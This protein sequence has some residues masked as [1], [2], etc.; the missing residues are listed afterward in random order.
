MGNV[1]DNIALYI[2]IIYFIVIYSMIRI[3]FSIIF[4]FLAYYSPVIEI[5]YKDGTYCSYNL[6]GRYHNRYRP[7]VVRPNGEFIWYYNGMI[8]RDGGEPAWIARDR[9]MYYVEG[10]M[11]REGDEPAYLKRDCIEFWKNGKP[12][13]DNGKPAIVSS[14]LVM[15]LEH[16]KLHNENGPSICIFQSKHIEFHLWGEQ[17]SEKKYKEIIKFLNKRKRKLAVEYSCRWYEW[18][19][20]LSTERGQRH[21]ERQY[22]KLLDI[23]NE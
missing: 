19:A 12:H 6:L 18:L 3:L 17:F 15:F 14:E 4:K 21:A 5:T 16:G 20:D 10:R 23:Y 22:Q 9:L 1:V 11:H 2:F 13:R 8:H 7:A